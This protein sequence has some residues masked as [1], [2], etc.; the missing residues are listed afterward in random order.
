LINKSVP[1]KVPPISPEA[2]NTTPATIY[3]KIENLNLA[4]ESARSIGCVVINLS[5]Q[6]IMEKREHIVLGMIWQIIRVTVCTKL[7]PHRKSA[8][9]KTVSVAY[10][11][12]KI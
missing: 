12:E 8:H 1:G 4:I 3:H 11:I 7:D 10:F 2:I 9:T 5:P 6:F